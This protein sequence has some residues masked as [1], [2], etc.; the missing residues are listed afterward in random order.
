MPHSRAEAGFCAAAR[1]ANPVDVKRKKTNSR[2]SMI[3][4]TAITPRSRVVISACEQRPVGEGAGKV[5]NGVGVDPPRQR[6]ED[7]QQPDGDD[8][9]GEHRRIFH[10]PDHNALDHH[11][12]D[13]RNHQRDR[14]G[15]PERQSG[16]HQRP[17]DVGREHRHFALSEVHQIGRAVDH[18]QRQRHAGVDGA[19]GQPREHLLQELVHRGPVSS[20]DRSGGF[21]DRRR[22][23]WRFPRRRRS[24]F[25]ADRRDPPVPAPG[26]RSAPPAA[27]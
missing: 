12:A 27:R 21:A 7:Q 2:T 9:R 16:I 5:L 8:H 17:G 11:A 4:V 6:I 3:S 15:G 20:R 26:W 18:H 23:L 10:R 14:K 13:E 24:R 1:M 19:G 22:A 25:R